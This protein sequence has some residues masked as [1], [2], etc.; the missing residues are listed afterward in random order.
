MDGLEW[1]HKI[2]RPFRKNYIAAPKR[3]F[4]IWY[5]KLREYED[6]KNLYL[7]NKIILLIKLKIRQVNSNYLD[8][9]TFR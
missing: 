6:R 7:I 2:M 3:G 5:L 4:L 9:K 8:E 1:S